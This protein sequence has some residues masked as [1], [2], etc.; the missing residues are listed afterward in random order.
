M[1]GFPQLL[2]FLI[3]LPKLGT[4]IL[5]RALQQV[6]LPNAALLKYGPHLQRVLID[7]VPLAKSRI[8]EHSCL[9]WGKKGCK[10]GGNSEHTATA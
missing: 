8:T 5:V 7:S 9:E 4:Q 6:P 10:M 3:P 2:G 1:T